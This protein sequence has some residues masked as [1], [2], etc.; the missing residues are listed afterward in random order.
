MLTPRA[1]QGNA[2][3]DGQFK[4]PLQTNQGPISKPRN[5]YLLRRERVTS[6][7]EPVEGGTHYHAWP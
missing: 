5:I 7:I 4:R 1:Q 6:P 3:P 2:C